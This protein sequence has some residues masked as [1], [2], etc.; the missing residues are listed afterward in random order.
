MRLRLF[1]VLALVLFTR[2]LIGQEPSATSPT[3]R[4]QVDLVELD[5][6]VTDSSGAFVRGLTAGD[7]EIVEDGVA[8]TVTALSEIDIPIEAAEPP[9][10]GLAPDP[11]VRTNTG[12]ESRLY[13]IAMDEGI[14]S[15]QILR[16]RMFLRRFV[17]QHFSATDI[18]AVVWVGRGLARDT[19]DFT[20]SKRLLLQAIDRF[21]G[22][23]SAEP[24]PASLVASQAQPLSPPGMTGSSL[25]TLLPRLSADR[26]A[27]SRTRMRSL[28]ELAE[29]ME[30]MRGRRKALLYVS[31]GLGF[32]MFDVI[33]YQGGVMGLAL[34]DAHAA[35]T[36]ATRGDVTI[37]AIDPRGLSPDGTSG[38]QTDAISPDDRADLRSS[39]TNLRTF[40]EFTGGFAVTDQNNFDK[41]F[42][43]IVQEGSS[44]Y[45]VGF[46]PTKTER[47][48]RF[49][50][51][52]VRVRRPGLS[53]QSRAGYMAPRGR[54]PKPVSTSPQRGLASSVAEAIANP[55]NTRGLPMRVTAVPY[56][57]GGRNSDVLLVVELDGR[58]LGLIEQGGK[59][60]GSVDVAWAAV[61]ADGQRTPGGHYRS[62]LAL[63]TD[64]YMRAVQDGIRFVSEFNIQPGRYQLRVGAGG[65][66]GPAGSVIADLEV[67]DFTR[68][69]L[70][71]SGLAVTS[72]RAA[73]VPTH[74]VKNRLE[75]V[76]PAPPSTR[77]DFDSTDEVA[78]YAEVYTG[79]G[80]Q[81]NGL[82]ATAALRD[83]AGRVVQ[84]VSAQQ[85]DGV[86]GIGF[87]ARLSFS[88]VPSGDYVLRFQAQPGPGGPAVGREI[89]LRVK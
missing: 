27:G 36:A 9:G 5:V 75:R 52:E 31:T 1:A 6:R 21:Q 45:I 42:T 86:R 8:Q 82:V 32:D 68:L 48:G 55:L 57:G 47:D 79:R 64:T 65:M 13:V 78:I 70:G 3:F 23:L 84:A 4:T 25:P 83:R 46:S 29:F 62:V 66:A 26:Q 49:R 24:P 63:E 34:A 37:Y 77:R 10:A 14:S 15:E 73:D 81:A 72:Q 28:R 89:P 50:K 54:P 12:D 22:G 39:R 35:M 88:G 2:E 20:S 60:A 71:M 87:T 41:A 53:V 80:V 58:R 44:Y 51:I 7:F 74:L 40:A 18:G 33:D 69:P 56:K 11:D 30:S 61:S 17:E 16:A 19:Q 85:S 67:P 59:H 43:R 76:L 38:A